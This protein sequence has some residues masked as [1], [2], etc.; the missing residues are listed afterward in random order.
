[1]IVVNVTRI[2]LMGLNH[3]YYEAIHSAWGDMITN[4]VML[5]LM[6]GVTVLGARREIFA[7]A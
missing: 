3:H 7:R 2:S 6:I 4:S 5:A 1:M